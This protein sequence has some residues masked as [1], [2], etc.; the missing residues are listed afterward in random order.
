MSM[1]LGGHE[2]FYPRPGWLAKGLLF[3]QS[4][5]PGSFSRVEVADALGVG[6][7][8]ARS[9]GWW[10]R[11]TGLA[12]RA[13]QSKPLELSELGKTIAQHDPFMGLLGTW[14]LVHASAVTAGTGSSLPWFFSHHLP[15]RFSRADLIEELHKSARMK[16]GKEFSLPRIQREVATV[17]K[18]Y[19][20][21]VPRAS[22]DPED[23]LGSPLHRLNLIRHFR[24]VDR[25]ER[26][27]S[28]PLPPEILG[29]VI[30]AVTAAKPPH[31]LDEDVE[32]DVQLSGS[33]MA[34]TGGM[35]GK[36]KL[37]LLE[38]AT[39]GSQQIGKEH[40]GA[41]RLAGATQ[42]SVRSAQPARWAGRLYS[43]IMERA[44]KPAA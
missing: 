35:L 20:V 4:N 2:T 31:L 10:L 15:S 28:T 19:A 8:M 37:E 27:T 30:S 11:M 40:M 39:D 33:E 44:G 13:N 36:G 43:R 18:A 7:N 5:R 41:R 12:E 26:T 14:W 24:T 3:L 34:L 21:P 25:Y 9:I 32:I 17:L 6:R 38:I 29:L 1:L 16:S 23:N 42:I 22:N